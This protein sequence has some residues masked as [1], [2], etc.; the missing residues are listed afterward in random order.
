MVPLRKWMYNSPQH[1][2]K[3]SRNYCFGKWNTCSEGSLPPFPSPH[4]TMNEYFYHQTW[5]VNFDG[6]Y[7]CW[8]EI[9]KY[10]ATNI[11]GDNTCNDDGCS[12]EET[13]ICQ[14]NTSQTNIR[15]W[16]HFACY[17]DVW[18][19]SFSFWFIFYHLCANHYCTSSTVFF[20]PL[21]ACFLLST[22][23]VHSLTMCASH[24]DFSKSYYIW[25]K[26]LIS[27]THHS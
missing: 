19:F 11:N 8:L 5:L 17:W 16:L 24:N 23:H 6:C 10:S 26:F 20:N 15:Q 7:H 22:T 21:N 3:Y 12:E 9:H 25:L 2:S 4:P 1:I 18:V 14:A 27:C 13:I